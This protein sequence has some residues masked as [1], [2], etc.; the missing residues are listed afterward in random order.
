MKDLYRVIKKHAPHWREIGLQLNLEITTLDIINEDYRKCATCFERT[1]QKWLDL[2]PNATWR[3]LE[4]AI[5]N[6]RRAH[7]GLKP[8]TDVCGEYITII[9]MLLMTCFN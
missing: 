9:G 3:E 4:V 8:V 7:L 2:T 5:T 1:L 6:A